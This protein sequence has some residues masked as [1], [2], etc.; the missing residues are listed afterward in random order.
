MPYET[1]QQSQGSTA[2]AKE[3]IN[4]V[5]FSLKLILFLKRDCGVVHS[6][7][8]VRNGWSVA[9]HNDEVCSAWNAA[10]DLQFRVHSVHA[11]H[12]R[13]KMTNDS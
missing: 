1:L 5:K 11:S 2:V 12:N 13:R 6:Q 3:T 10:T 8:V 7:A 4:L 9:A